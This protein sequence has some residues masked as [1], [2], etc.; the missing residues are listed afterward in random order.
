[1]LKDKQIEL[2]HSIECLEEAAS[3]SRCDLADVEASVQ[4]KSK[5]LYEL[6]RWNDELDRTLKDMTNKLRERQEELEAC[7]E[8]SEQ[9]LAQ[10]DRQVTC[11]CSQLV[12]A[13]QEA[14]DWKAKHEN[15]ARAYREL[16]ASRDAEMCRTR[17]T[18]DDL[19]RERCRLMD[20]MSEVSCRLADVETDN[21]LLSEDAQASNT[22]LA[23]L[24][25]EVN[26]LEQW[27]SH[28]RL[29]MEVERTKAEAE[30][31]LLQEEKTIKQRKLELIE[32][33]VERL[34]RNKDEYEQRLNQQI[35]QQ[36]TGDC[37]S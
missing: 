5:Q 20:V 31:K 27:A 17:A 29:V 22:R 6:Q 28:E 9:R 12:D 3:R 30:I 21:R 24:M 16:K 34:I 23:C 7:A 2:E 18:I 35:C 25:H 32:A 1:M 15:A 37:C 4:N 13:A 14:S 26:R 11:A 33:D 8:A 10:A 19:N 36:R